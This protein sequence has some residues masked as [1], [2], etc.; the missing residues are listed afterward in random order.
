[1]SAFAPSIR[2]RPPDAPFERIM[3][4]SELVEAYGKY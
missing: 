2:G 1:M 4:L 3:R